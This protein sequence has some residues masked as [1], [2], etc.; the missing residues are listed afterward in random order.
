MIW[1][2]YYS[3]I[4]YKFTSMHIFYIYMYSVFPM[5]KMNMIYMIYKSLSIEK[6]NLKICWWKLLSLWPCRYLIFLSLYSHLQHEQN[7]D[8]FQMSDD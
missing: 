3:P 4:S 8:L 1:Y 7:V 6:I 5:Y 2:L